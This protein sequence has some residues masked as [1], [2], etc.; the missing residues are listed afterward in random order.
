[1]STWTQDLLKLKAVKI[2]IAIGL[3]ALGIVYFLNYNSPEN[4]C[5]RKYKS[6]AAYL[7]NQPANRLQELAQETAIDELVEECLNKG[8]FK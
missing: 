2:L 4:K 7:P 6:A 8:E 5:R 1:M 3:V